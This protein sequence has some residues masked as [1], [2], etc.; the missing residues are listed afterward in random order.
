[1][2]RGEGRGASDAARW[3]STASRGYSGKRQIHN[4]L[5]VRIVVESAAQAMRLLDRLETLVFS[6]KLL[7]QADVPT[8]PPPGMCTDRVQVLEVHNRL[9]G[10]LQQTAPGRCA[11]LPPALV[12]M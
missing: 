9:E 3:H 8:A 7:H 5:S 11:S 6:P 10:G 12:A 4:A 2:A 1:M